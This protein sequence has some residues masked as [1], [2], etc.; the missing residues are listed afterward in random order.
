MARSVVSFIICFFSPRK[1]GKIP[2]LTNIFSKGLV[3]PPTRW[4]LWLPP[5]ETDRTPRAY[6]WGGP[7]LSTNRPFWKSML[8]TQVEPDRESSIGA[9]CLSHPQSPLQVFSNEIT[10]SA[11]LKRL[12]R[13]WFQ[14][15][16]IF[17]PTWGRFPF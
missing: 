14:V 17:T 13:W 1:L 6:Y 7:I 11:F 2:N 10:S 12:S 15:F 8:Y 5:L 4:G 9:H 3:Q 16:C